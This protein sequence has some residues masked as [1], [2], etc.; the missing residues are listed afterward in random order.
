MSVSVEWA[1]VAPGRVVVASSERAWVHTPVSFGQID[2]FAEPMEGAGSAVT[3]RQLLDGAI[4]AAGRDAGPRGE[5]PPLSAARWAWRLAGYYRTT[6]ATPRLMATAAERFAASGR[7]ALAA[8]ARDKVREET[9]HDRLALRDLGALGFDP[10]RLVE[11]LIPPTADDLVRYFEAR[12]IDDPDP[13]GCVG[14]A[15]T[16][17]RLA[18]ERDARYIDAVNAI[19]PSGIDAT[20]CLRVHSAEGSDA[21]HVDEIVELVFA[22]SAAERILVARAC[23]ETS[24]IYCTPPNEG[25]VTEQ[26]LASKL[27]GLTAGA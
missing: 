24:L 3:T 2:L 27:S 5:A 25:F 20:R 4:A 9:G 10:E 11:T 21:S 26:E 8:W 12:V 14:Y 15:Y 23:Y 6:H 18:V 16:L 1:E 22:L 13:I 19:L 17:E 7:D